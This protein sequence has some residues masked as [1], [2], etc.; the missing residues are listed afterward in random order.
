MGRIAFAAGEAYEPIDDQFFMAYMR[1]QTTELDNTE[2]EIFFRQQGS[3]W[4]TGWMEAK[5]EASEFFT[6]TSNPPEVE[7]GENG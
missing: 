2:K 1:T 4:R 5:K 3:E 6:I 7:S